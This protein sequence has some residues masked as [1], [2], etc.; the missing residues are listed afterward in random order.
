[1]LRGVNRRPYEQI[2]NV[3]VRSAQAKEGV[4]CKE[5]VVSRLR[6]LG[7]L[8]GRTPSSCVQ[9]GVFVRGA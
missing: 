1:M 2:L 8:R 5:G 4:W 3:V 9:N 6:K 7:N